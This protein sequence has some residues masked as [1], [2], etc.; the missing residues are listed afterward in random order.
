VGF[1]IPYTDNGL[2]ECYNNTALAA[3]AFSPAI[4][5][6]FDTRARA[7]IGTI[8]YHLQQWLSAFDKAMSVAT[9]PKNRRQDAVELFNKVRGIVSAVADC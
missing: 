7:A 4:R 2:N 6:Y 8:N 1:T 9:G 3:M 5:R